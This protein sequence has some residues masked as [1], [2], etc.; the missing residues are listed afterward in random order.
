MVGLFVHIASLSQMKFSE[1]D[2]FMENKKHV[3][4]LQEVTRKYE[5]SEQ[6]S[7]AYEQEIIQMVSTLNIMA[8]M[9]ESDKELKKELSDA[10]LLAKEELS[11]AR[12]TIDKLKDE[13]SK[14]DV[15]DT[16][17][18]I[19]TTKH[20]RRHRPNKQLR[21]QRPLLS[22]DRNAPQPWDQYSFLTYHHAIEFIP[23]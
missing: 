2:E 9:R 20:R 7:R 17:G 6:K 5:E 16:N 1:H 11:D 14:N 21:L 23:I 8:A 10:L 15:I 22:S 12:G 18:I 19:A 13:K 3:E 4:S